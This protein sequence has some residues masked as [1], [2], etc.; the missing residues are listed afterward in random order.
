[1]SRRGLYEDWLTEDGL[2]R[3]ESYA[4]DGLTDEQIAKEI[5]VTTATLYNWKKAHKPI[6]E[7]LK[8][9]KAPVDAGV[10][11]SL[12]QRAMGYDVVERTSALQRDPETGEMAMVV[13]KEVTKHIPPDTTAQIFWL[14]NRKPA[15]WRDKPVDTTPEANTVRVVFDPLPEVSADGG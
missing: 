6:V 4:R 3:L 13:V 2:I 8:R 10:E 12:L 9:G 7:A 5:G 1:M 14:K 11:K 15:Q